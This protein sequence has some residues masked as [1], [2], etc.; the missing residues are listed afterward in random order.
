VWTAFL[1]PY[2]LGVETVLVGLPFDIGTFVVVYT[3][4]RNALQSTSTSNY[5]TW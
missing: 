1:V 3:Q 5:A 2:I 4:L